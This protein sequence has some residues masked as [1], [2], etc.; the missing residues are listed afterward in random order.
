MKVLA[1]VRGRI[2]IKRE[3]AGLGADQGLVAMEFSGVHEGLDR[4]PDIALRTLMAVVDGG[5]EHIDSGPQPG[6]NGCDVGLVRGVAGLAEIGSQSD[7]RQPK[8]VYSRHLPGLAE[9]P[10]IAQVG[11]AVAIA[12]GASGRG[13]SG[14][15]GKQ[16]SSRAGPYS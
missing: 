12:S 4:N 2:A 15:H 3:I 5:I 7:G 6:F 1:R 10:G 9:V 8:L 16:C 13:L 11:E 14:K